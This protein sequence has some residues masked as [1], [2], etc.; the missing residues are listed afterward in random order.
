MPNTPTNVFDI[1]KSEI[2]KLFQ[3]MVTEMPLYHP[4]L[5]KV[6]YKAIA[7]HIE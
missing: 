3:N 7:K 5:T 1:A 2:Y 4:N 6:P